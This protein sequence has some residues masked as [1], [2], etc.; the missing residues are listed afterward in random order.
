MA[1]LQFAPLESSVSSS[2]WS[3]LARLKLDELRLSERPLDVVG[4]S[5]ALLC[6]TL[7]KQRCRVP[8]GSKSS[9]GRVS[10]ALG[11]CQPAAGTSLVAACACAAASLTRC[12][13]G[14]QAAQCQWLSCPRH[15]ARR[16]HA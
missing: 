14:Q 4:A 16:E 7:L 11:G 12:A 5:A 13:G 15:A 2:F 6:R 8:V 10:A 3:A 1:S 9:R